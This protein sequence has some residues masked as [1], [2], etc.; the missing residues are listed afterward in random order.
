MVEEKAAELF[1]KVRAALPSSAHISDIRFEGCEI[2]LYT[3]S[4]EFFVDPGD[5]IKNM[6]STFKKRIL[7]RPDPSICKDPEDAE[8]E[9]RNVVPA[10]AG[11]RD[12]EFEPDVSKVTIEAD[13]PGL[14]IGK[15]GETLRAIKKAALWS[16]IIHRAPAIPSETIK[17]LRELVYRESAFRKDFLDKVGKRIHGGWKPTEWARITALGGFREVGRSAI[18]LQT[19]ESRL[20]L[21]CGV[22]PGT[23]EFPYF[24]IPEFDIHSL[25][26]IVLS[27]SHMDHC[28]LIPALYEMGYDGP[29]YCTLPSR[30]LMVLLCMD[31]IELGQREGRTPPF[32][33]KGIKEAVRHCIPLEYGE[34]NDITPDIRLTLWNA[35]HILGSALCHFHIGEGFHNFLYTGDM[36]FDRTALYEPASTEFTRAETVLIESTY[37][38]AEDILPRRPEAEAALANAVKKT[39]ERGGKV[40][41]PSF[42]VERAQD[43][44]VILAKAGIECPVWLDGMVWDATAIHTAY[45]EFMNREIQ[46]AILQQ[47]WN[48]FTE[49]IFK[50]IGSEDERKAVLESREPA[51]IIA[52]AG[53]LTGGPSVWWLRNLAEDAK[54]SMIFVGYQSEGSLGRRIQKG[55]KE[56]PMEDKGRTVAVPIK[57]EI[58]TVDGLSGH[59]DHKQLLNWLARLRQVPERILVNHGEN[60]KC[61]EFSRMAHKFFRCESVAPKLL[62]TIR[63]K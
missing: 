14:V 9:I 54:N 56:I 13:K 44:Q 62:E 26:A 16:P 25:N 45:P 33:T 19:P 58:T 51:V 61:V 18:L 60:A 2:V 49:P 7:L 48:P 59:S 23:N 57:M 5:S 42:A 15:G 22:K 38:L 39:V 63:L 34:V 27:H 30:D 28:G 31:Y 10:E 24:N 6:V 35:G 50:R 46:R 3:K 29:L 21:D 12:I 4:K 37:G 17:V 36:K 52:T 1:E 11:I 43:V 47:G 32:T 20:L 8:R 55:W 41:I 53:M 40:L